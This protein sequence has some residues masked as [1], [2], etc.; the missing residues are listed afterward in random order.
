[1][2]LLERNKGSCANIPHNSVRY[3]ALSWWEAVRT[4]YDVFGEPER[5]DREK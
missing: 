2:K 1:M 4:A 3:T 5:S